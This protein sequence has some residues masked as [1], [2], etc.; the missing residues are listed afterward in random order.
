M[1]AEELI[2]RG[3]REIINRRQRERRRGK[4]Q[5]N[6]GDVVFSKENTRKYGCI[7]KIKQRN[8]N[9]LVDWIGLQK[10]RIRRKYVDINNVHLAKEVI[11]LPG[12]KICIFILML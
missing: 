2:V 1:D 9:V 7:L 3:K 5:Y 4:N 8:G 12:N 6:K 11:A 10:E